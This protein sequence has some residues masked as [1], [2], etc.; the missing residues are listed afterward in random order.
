[1]V[2]LDKYTEFGGSVCCQYGMQGS[3][4]PVY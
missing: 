3:C 2:L 4:I 1:M